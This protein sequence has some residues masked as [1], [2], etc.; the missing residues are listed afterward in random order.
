MRKEL[1]LLNII[2]ILVA[3][4]FLVMA[5]ISVIESG[6]F[7]TIDNLFIITVSLVMALMF[8]VNPL[9]YL[10]SE[11]RLPIPGVKKS[12][13]APAGGGGEWGQVRSQP[14]PPLLDAKGRPV[15][16]D[17]RAMVSRMDANK[18]AQKVQ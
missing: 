4:G 3:L 2:C 13:A 9:L 14:A 15:P 1:G 16:P 8:A 10:K 12:I 6:D 5:V 17:V 7:L 11:G 18:E